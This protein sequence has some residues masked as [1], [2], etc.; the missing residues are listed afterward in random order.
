MA[1]FY[2]HRSLPLM[3]MGGRRGG[4][5]PTQIFEAFALLNLIREVGELQWRPPL[6]LGVMALNAASFFAKGRVLPIIGPLT[7][8]ACGFDG[9]RAYL[10]LR[11]LAV[12]ARGQ[13]SRL[14]W[15][16]ARGG[17]VALL[18]AREL[19]R[20][21]LAS[22][23]LHVDTW[24]LYYNMTSL[25]WK[26]AELEAQLGWRGLTRLLVFSLL[27]APMFALATSVAL[28][29]NGWTRTLRATTVGFSGVLFSLKVVVNSSPGR[30]S[31]LPFVGIAVPSRW[32]TWFELVL[33]QL[34]V[35]NTSFVGHLGGILSGLTYLIL[36]RLIGGNPGRS[37]G[38]W[39]PRQRTRHARGGGAAIPNALQSLLRVFHDMLRQCQR[40]A[41][42]FLVVVMPSRRHTR[43]RFHG[44]GTTGTRN[45][46]VVDVD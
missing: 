31:V 26:G 43:P 27:T 16:A 39:A 40:L 15:G 24:H 9:Q 36:E 29:W 8:S 23:L 10:L 12:A 30:R 37:G 34:L 2:S 18:A 45:V 7:V 42:S 11:V 41:R 35:P 3:R 1:A 17:G 25:L 6:T 5:R 33:I 13:S 14:R 46:P 21:T 4:Q 20:R 22:Q 28:A 19:M 32:A 38:Q 44:S